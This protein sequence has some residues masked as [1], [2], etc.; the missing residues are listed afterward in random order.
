MNPTNEDIKQM[1]P[2]IEHIFFG[3][4]WDDPKRL[5]LSEELFL[6]HYQNILRKRLD[7]SIKRMDQEYID[8]VYDDYSDNKE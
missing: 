3:Q 6:E 4:S 7:Y 1:L 5:T 8:A 2:I